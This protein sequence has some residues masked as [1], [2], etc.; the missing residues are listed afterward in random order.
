M[1]VM[2]MLAGRISGRFGSRVSLILGSAVT[3]MAFAWLAVA[4]A[5]PYDFLIAA[6]LMG[7]GIGLAFAALGTLVIAAVPPQ[8]SGVASG[9]NTVMRTL[10]GALGGQLSATF[11]A[12]HVSD[13]VPTIT[14]FTETFVMATVF[15]VV[16]VFASTLVPGQRRRHRGVGQR[17]A[18][19][20]S[21]ESLGEVAGV[22]GGAGAPDAG[23]VRAAA[24]DQPGGRG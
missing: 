14:G 1:F 9:M 17:P 13:G 15:L 21:G 23:A 11:I 6:A 18:G 24:V 4:H 8:Q 7:I 16:C 19:S 10:G 20:G 3:A 22:N 2:G 5:H 12:G